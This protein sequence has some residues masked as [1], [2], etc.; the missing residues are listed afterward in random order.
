MEPGSRDEPLRLPSW[1]IE[2]DDESAYELGDALR[3]L[4]GRGVPGIDDSD[5][6]VLRPREL[7]ESQ[8]RGDEYRKI[9][10]T[11]KSERAEYCAKFPALSEEIVAAVR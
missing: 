8:G 9:V 5:S 7:Y 6:A 2:R 10:A 11:L 4:G 1:Q 3:V